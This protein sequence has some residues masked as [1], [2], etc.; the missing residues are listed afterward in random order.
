MAP[1]WPKRVWSLDLLE[2]SMAPPRV[3]PLLEKLL[4]QPRSNILP[5]EFAGALASRLET[6]AKGVRSTGFSKDVAERVARA[7][8]QKAFAL[9]CNMQQIARFLHDVFKNDV[10]NVCMIEGYKSAIAATLKARG[11]NVG[12]EPHIC[13]LISSFYTDSLVPRWLPHC[14]VTIVLDAFTKSPFE[15]WDMA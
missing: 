2:L 7:L 15:L 4:L 14:D 12:T 1:W 10:L 9:A 6:I 3:L 13:E 5:S 8:C 11:M